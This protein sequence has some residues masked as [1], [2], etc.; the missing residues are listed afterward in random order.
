L[1]YKLRHFNIRLFFTICYMS[2]SPRFYPIDTDM[3]R[4]RFLVTGGAGFIG[5]HIV[6]Y[7]LQHGAGKVYV[8]DNFST[9]SRKNLAHLS[10]FHD[11]LNIIEGDIRDSETCLNACAKVDY[12][13]HQAALGSVPRSLKDPISSNEVNVGGFVKMLHACKENGVKRIVYASSSSVY[14]SSPHLPK[15]EEHIGKPLS[16]YAVTKLANEIYADVFAQSYGMELIGLRY[17]NVFG[18]RQS[19]DGA[20]AAV[21]PLFIAHLQAGNA[22]FINGDGTQSRDFTYIENAVQANIRAL[23]ATE[24][25]AL[26]TVYNVAVG[27][28]FTVN[29]LYQTIAQLLGCE[30]IAPQYRAPRDGDIAHSLADISKAQK[31]LGYEPLLTFKAG[32]ALT[33]N[34]FKK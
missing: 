17:F 5:S 34:S 31:W 11:Q 23:F 14:G 1:P 26:G 18:P 28:R 7:L 30:H 33:V 12:V 15:V 24:P 3:N 27:E 32:L 19:P 4:L 6:E 9:G 20:Y 25:Q 21:I 2:L 10:A 16:P 22:P 13:L 29:E 8:L